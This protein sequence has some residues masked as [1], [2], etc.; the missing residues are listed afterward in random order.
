MNL[1][2]RAVFVAAFS[3]LAV[4]AAAAP[5]AQANVLSLLPGSCGSQIE[6]QPF[7]QWG[8]QA[9]YTR[10][11]GGDFEAGSPSWLLSGGA[12]VAAGNESYRVGGG[13]DVSSLTL[14]T[15]SSTTSLASC[16]SIY[17]PTVRL[18]LR[19][20]GSASSHLKVEAL[21]PGLLGGV[22]AATL[23]RLSG[24]SRWAPSPAMPLLVS[25]LLATLSLNRTVIGF[26]FTPADSTGAWSI[27]DVY[28]DPYARG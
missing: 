18:F 16:T 27:D 4:V 10:V 28:L 5:A 7:A 17:H 26:R 22:Q 8:D 20:T 11:P 3:A 14:P 6:S 19:N 13:S 2:T 23:G 25:N 9:Y 15:G 12:K 21:Y 1:R 24:S